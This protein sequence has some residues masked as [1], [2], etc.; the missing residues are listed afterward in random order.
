MKSK[1]LSTG[2][3]VDVNALQ[4]PEEAER[5]QGS[6]VFPESRQKLFFYGKNGPEEGA[7]G[8]SI[9]SWGKRRLGLVAFLEKKRKKNPPGSITAGGSQRYQSAP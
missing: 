3:R 8:T 9:K 7:T 1:S 2:Q 5:R 4:A 6:F